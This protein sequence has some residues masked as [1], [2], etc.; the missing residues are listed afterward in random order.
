MLLALVPA[1]PI[2]LGTITSPYAGTT[3][4]Q[5]NDV[6]LSCG[7]NAPEQGFSASLAPGGSITIGIDR[8]A[9]DTRHELRVGG[10]YPG[11]VSVICA[12]NP[13]TD[14]YINT[15]ATAVMVYYIVD[16]YGATHGGFTLAWVVSSTTPP[17]LA[18][19]PGPTWW[20]TT[21]AIPLIDLDTITSPYAGTT[22]GNG[23]RVQL[24]CG[25]NA[26]EQGFSASLAPGGS[27]MIGIDRA[28]YDTRHELRVGGDYPGDASVICADNPATDVYTNNCTTA[29]T[30]YYIVDAYAATHGGF[31]L[32]WRIQTGAPTR[33]CTSAP[34]VSP[35]PTASPSRPPP[36]CTCTYVAC[37]AGCNEITQFGHDRFAFPCASPCAHTCNP[38]AV[39]TA[40]CSSTGAGPDSPAHHGHH[41]CERYCHNV[42]EGRPMP[43]S[44]QTAAEFC[45][46]YDSRC[47]TEPNDFAEGGNWHVI[48]SGTCG[49]SSVTSKVECDA[50]LAANVEGTSGNSYDMPSGAANRDTMPAG[51]LWSPHGSEDFNGNLDSAVECHTWRH[52]LCRTPVSAACEAWYEAADAGTLGTSRSSTS[53]GATRA[54]YQHHLGL[55]TAN[56]TDM[57]ALHC[58]HARGTAVCV[59]A[60]AAP[61]TH[62]PTTGSPTT[63]AP[64]ATPTTA[65]PTTRAPVT[66][67]PTTRAP[68]TAAPTTA[69]PTSSV[70]TLSPSL[71]PT[72]TVPTAGADANK[73]DA[74]RD[75]GNGNADSVV[76]ALAAVIA[77]LVL[78]IGG[79]YYW[80]HHGGGSCSGGVPGR[81]GAS[82]AAP[83]RGGR[84]AATV[85]NQV[86][87]ADPPVP[88]PAY[89]IVMPPAATVFA[90]FNSSPGAQAAATGY[91]EVPAARQP[92][93]L[94][95]AYND[96][97]GLEASL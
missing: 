4:G 86:Y 56:D 59:A 16:A 54:C 73:N 30:V 12:D 82:A 80:Q 35:P 44:P 95:S 77:T 8:A 14:V 3:T 58:P 41:D 63:G 5:A 43:A 76:I 87:M 49:A 88:T 52:C 24:S 68:T 93:V 48:T 10:D 92:I 85:R 9:Y 17:T 21:V 65:T 81:A 13:A 90:E 74:S 7:G 15:G 96:D 72:S 18:P 33:T 75:D 71:S 28:A 57:Q 37:T 79:M 22:T 40:V 23:N 55:A 6:A 38:T 29:V 34:T 78:V 60:T 83:P 32:A 62:A 70:P 89:A 45:A 20:P 46:D 69:R 51:C 1:T 50:A 36:V 94:E 84:G 39:A 61:T 11:D 42:T 91:M 31:T 26:P 64:T 2:D 53:R 19:T 97:D 47:G 66:A 27:I 67:A 25:G